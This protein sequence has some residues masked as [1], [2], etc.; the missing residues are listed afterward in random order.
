MNVLATSDLYQS[1]LINSAATTRRE[2]PESPERAAQRLTRDQLHYSLSH[3][4]VMQGSRL[5]AESKTEENQA[6]EE[7]PS[8]P[9]SLGDL[10]RSV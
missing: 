3:Q 2:R 5:Y 4:D 7:E 1:S 10:R 6:S 9:S 8:G